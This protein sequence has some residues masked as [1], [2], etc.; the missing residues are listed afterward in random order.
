[1]T[2]ERRDP[3]RP[4]VAGEATRG[5]V[6]RSP[7][8]RPL[9][10]PKAHPLMAKKQVA[11]MIQNALFAHAKRSHED[12]PAIHRRA[13]LLG[14]RSSLHIC[15]DS[16]VRTGS[17][18]ARKA[19]ISAP[20]SLDRFDGRGQTIHTRSRTTITAKS[21]VRAEYI[22][23]RSIYL[24][25]ALAHLRRAPFHRPAPPNLQACDCDFSAGGASR[26]RD[27]AG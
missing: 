25:G 14:Y 3:E 4:L 6:L 9:S 8:Q 11:E 16:L 12:P 18:S 23:L 19:W 27:A 22:S 1:M 5:R 10:K 7:A 17:E 2:E 20:D 15:K 24:D 13:P 21:G 26:G